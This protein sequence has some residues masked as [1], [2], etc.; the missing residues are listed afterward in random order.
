VPSEDVNSIW[1]SKEIIPASPGA[2]GTPVN[3]A[4]EFVLSVDERGGPIVGTMQLDDKLII[5]KATTLSVVTGEGPA[6]SGALNDF[7]TPQIIATDAGFESG[8]S[9]VLMPLGI[10][11]KSPKG[12]YLLDRSLSVSY[13]G[14]PVETFNSYA[15]TS[16]VLLYDRNEVWFGTTTNQIIYNYYFNLWSTATF[17][18]SHA[19]NYQGKYLGISGVNLFK[20]TPGIYRRENAVGTS[21]GYALKVTTGW[22]SFA[23]VQGYQRVY[24]MLILGTYKS[25]HKLQVDFAYEFVDSSAQT[26]VFELSQTVDSPLQ[27]RIF[28]SRQKCET[29]KMTLQDLAPTVGTWA[30]SFSLSNMAFEIGVKKGLNKLPASKSV[31]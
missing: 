28:L 15:C 18:W 26:T 12:Y 7:S 16:A 29:V 22:M 10:L 6:N 31:G 5:G 19:C 23:N 11:F 8:R 17:S 30:Q 20:E 14:A 21:S 27:N 2:I 3:W 9:L 4:F 1:Y 13:I 25:A 24:K